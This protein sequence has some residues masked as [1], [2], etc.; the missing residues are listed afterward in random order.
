MKL[1]RYGPRGEEK[2]GLLDD[3]GHLRD[4]SGHVNDLQGDVLGPER[5]LQGFAN[6]AL[7]TVLALLVMGQAMVRAG[8]LD[9]GARWVMKLGAG[10][11]WQSVALTLLAAASVSA[12]LN[13]IPVVVIFIPIMQA[14]AIRFDSTPSK[15]MI[16]LRYAAVLAG[17]PTLVC[18]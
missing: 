4:L 10:R 18:R 3:Q 8:V 11:G 2:P 7:I 6:P 13:N 9:A 17:M 16:P 5:L 12:F 15:F 1:L 14:V